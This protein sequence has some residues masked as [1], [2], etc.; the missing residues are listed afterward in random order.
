MRRGNNKC[1]N[2]IHYV[3]EYAPFIKRMVMTCELSTRNFRCKDNFVRKEKD[4][5]KGNESN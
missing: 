1:E 3:K 2:C 4:D 5:G